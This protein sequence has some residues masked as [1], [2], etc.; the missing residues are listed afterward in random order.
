[1]EELGHEQERWREGPREWGKEGWV[2]NHRRKRCFPGAVEGG[3][4]GP[5]TGLGL[6]R[7]AHG[8]L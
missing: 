2:W 8:G 7:E 6:W 5:V 4:R 3:P 1:M